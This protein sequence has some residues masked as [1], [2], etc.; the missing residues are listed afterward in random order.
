M[1]YY[2]ILLW[3]GCW[4]S[5]LAQEKEKK[6]IHVFS[7]GYQQ[8]PRTQIMLDQGSYS[9]QPIRVRGIFVEYF[10]T[11]RQPDRSWGWGL[12]GAIM[13]YSQWWDLLESSSYYTPGTGA[14][15]V[16]KFDHVELV[17]WLKR[18]FIILQKP[19]FTI[20]ANTQGGPAFNVNGNLHAKEGWVPLRS[21]NQTGFLACEVVH[22]RRQ[23]PWLPYFRVGVGLE[24]GIHLKNNRVLSIIPFV[25]LAFFQVDKET[26]SSYPNDPALR[27]NGHFQWNRNL[28][29]CKLGLG[30]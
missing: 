22:E 6:N 27:S 8:S 5:A 18:N 19:G 3:T 13:F 12:S 25:T 1:K 10:C 24:Y 23:P 30:H 16:D 4:M 26:F 14:S 28:F 29:G 7:F 2:F 17:G 11:R 20:R 15:G 9:I 21:D